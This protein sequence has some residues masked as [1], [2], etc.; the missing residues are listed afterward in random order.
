MQRVQFYPSSK[1]FEILETEAQS[2]GVSVSTLVSD[3]LNEYYGLSKNVTKSV[4]ELTVIVLKEVEDYI[5]TLPKGEIFD[6]KMAS[7]TYNDI[8]MTNGKRPQA[9]RASIGRSFGAKLGKGSFSN[10]RKATQ[11]GK[12]ILSVNNALMY[13][14]F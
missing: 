8:P 5:S 6:L 12:Q 1:L 4:T 11:N 7:A 14:V 9:I 10:V 2:K 3:I 13:E